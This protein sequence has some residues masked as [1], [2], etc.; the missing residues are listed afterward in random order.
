[1][2]QFQREH[3]GPAMKALESHLEDHHGVPYDEVREA[4]DEEEN[5]RGH[6]SRGDYDHLDDFDGLDEADDEYDE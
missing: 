1:M 5:P 4:L 6:E 2:Q 3:L